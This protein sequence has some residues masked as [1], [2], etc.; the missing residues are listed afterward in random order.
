MALSNTKQKTETI[1]IFTQKIH[2]NAGFSDTYKPGK[3][4]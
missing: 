2:V 1:S 4:D 3:F